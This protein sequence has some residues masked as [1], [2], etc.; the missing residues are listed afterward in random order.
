MG[1]C[2]DEDDA[3]KPQELIERYKSAYRA[4]N[5]RGCI[6]EYRN[7]WFT[8]GSALV[9]SKYR[10]PDIVQMLRTLENRAVMAS[11]DDQK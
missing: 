10:M 6:A 2:L 5:K 9:Q 7:G 8:V 3:M 11:G 4:V 1:L